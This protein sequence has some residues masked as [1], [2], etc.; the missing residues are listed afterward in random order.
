MPS[1]AWD[2]NHHALAVNVG[3]L[4]TAQFRSPHGSGVQRHEQG[5][6]EEITGRVDEL[7]HFLRAEHD[8]Q[9]PGRLGKG[10]VLG[11]KMAPQGLDEQEA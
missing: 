3:D 6:V 2:T 10:N 8:W 11:Q 7:C 1:L 4:E 9:P 5:A